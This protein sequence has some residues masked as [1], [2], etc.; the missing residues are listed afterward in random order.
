MTLEHNRTS[1]F[2]WF[3]K[4]EDLKVSK[5]KK[6]TVN[7]YGDSTS[8]GFVAGLYS[9]VIGKWRRGYVG[10][11]RERY[12]NI[13]QDVGLGVIQP[14]YLWTYT[15][16]W[17][18][19]ETD[20]ETA[21][22]RNY[23]GGERGEEYGF[24]GTSKQTDEENATATLAFN[25]TGINLFMQQTDDS[26]TVNVAIDG[27]EATLYDLESTT[28]TARRIQITGLED[29]AHSIVLT[30]TDDAKM[31]YLLGAQEVR[32]D[33]GVIVNN[34]SQGGAE[35]RNIESQNL[36]LMASS[37]FFDADLTI[38]NLILNGR[39]SN[40]VE[41][42]LNQLEVIIGAASQTGDVLIIIPP[43]AIAEATTSYF[44]SV[45]DYADENGVA[46][47]DLYSELDGNMAVMYD[48]VH[49]NIAGHFWEGRMVSDFIMPNSMQLDGLNWKTN[50]KQFLRMI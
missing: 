47:I 32:G 30:K 34:M 5:D 11:I 38:I 8:V 29:G 26:G 45:I 3:D 12:K 33:Y 13:F 49:P 4:V 17:S 42:Y 9:D 37:T 46:L 48:N 41:S 43:A 6:L 19:R 27:G 35:I 40:T 25:G 44:D 50:L 7:V 23:Y 15:G 22:G 24:I 14:N 31:I 1:L 39:V 10:R 2:S 21:I 16:T 18:T 28:N 20:P 36:T